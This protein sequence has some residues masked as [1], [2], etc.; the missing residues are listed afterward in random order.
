MCSDQIKIDE[1]IK[2]L[3]EITKFIFFLRG[4]T[5]YTRA[6]AQTHTYTDTQIEAY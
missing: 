5:V 4:L 6:R 1:S 3:M 2:V